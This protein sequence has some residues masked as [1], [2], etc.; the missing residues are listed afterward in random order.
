MKGKHL[1]AL[2]LGAFAWGPLTA[3]GAEI[4]H[5]PG[6]TGDV[7][8]I[9][10]SG[11]IKTGD[12]QKF[13]EL[14]VRYPEAIVGLDSSGGAIVPAL[15]I[16]RMI[17]LRGYITA[18]L[19][20]AT[21]TSACA[22]IWLAGNPRM[23]SSSGALGFHATYK[24]VGGRLVETGVGNA[25]VG[26]YLSQMNLPEKAVIFATSASPYEISW[27]SEANRYAAGIDFTPIMPERNSDKS[28][29]AKSPPLPRS[30]LPI[31]PPVTTSRNVL[32][33]SPFDAPARPAPIVDRLK[34]LLRAPGT[35]AEIAAKA[36]L[37]ANQTDIFADHIRLLYANDKLVEKMAAELGTAGKAIYGDQ[38][39][40]IGYEIA[41]AMVQKLLFDGMLRL[42]NRDV[43]M[44]VNEM[45]L[46]SLDAT[47]SEC[48]AILTCSPEM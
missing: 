31:P 30:P 40:Q 29:S 38:A 37:D 26:H 14:S 27:L 34:S 22:L 39:K 7:A 47:T 1:F 8:V 36:G 15:E 9:L 25:M 32:A 18:V 41:A 4:D 3:R 33:V 46:I 44:F 12:D 23:L 42:S 11:E 5:S 17:R 19:D 20:D 10:I 21:C 6:T 2:C 16:G 43:S 35:Q 48:G 24:D 28:A 13:R 45:S